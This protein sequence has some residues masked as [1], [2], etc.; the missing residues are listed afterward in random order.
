[1]ARECSLQMITDKMKTNSSNTKQIRISLTFHMDLFQFQAFISAQ[2]WKFV[3]GMKLENKKQGANWQYK[4]IEWSDIPIECSSTTPAG[5]ISPQIPD[6]TNQN[7]CCLNDGDG[8]C[9]DT[10]LP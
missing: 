7:E 9:K 6:P 2:L 1:M 3:D 10:G 4:D 5:C 8:K